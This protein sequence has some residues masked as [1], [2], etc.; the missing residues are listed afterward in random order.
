MKSLQLQTALQRCI[1]K[2]I[3]ETIAGNFYRDVNVAILN[4][5]EEL[6]IDTKEFDS[7]VDCDNSIHQKFSDSRFVGLAKDFITGVA[8]EFDFDPYE[9]PRP[10]IVWSQGL[11]AVQADP[12]TLI[13]MI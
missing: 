4:V 13:A 3:D 6:D 1:S 7:L 8:V 11:T 12:P 5:L 2:T 9:N 10:Q